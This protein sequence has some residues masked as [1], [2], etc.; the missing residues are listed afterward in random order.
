QVNAKAKKFLVDNG[1]PVGA[2]AGQDER[3]VDGGAFGV[4]TPCTT[5]LFLLR[6]LQTRDSMLQGLTAAMRY[7]AGIG[8]PTHLDQGRFPFSVPVVG[9][10]SDGAASFDRYR[11]H[12]S[13]R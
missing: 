2:V 5:A 8:V 11:A 13:V 3:Y 1:V 10:P 9:D 6:K 4:A 12:D 7:A